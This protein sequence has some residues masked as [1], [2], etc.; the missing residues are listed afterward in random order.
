MD[1]VDVYASLGFGRRNE[2]REENDGRVLQ[3]GVGPNLCCDVP[4][5]CLWHHYIEEDQIRQKIPGGLMSPRRVVLFEDQIAP[6][7]FEK[8]F[9][10]MRSVLVVI[11]N[12]NPPR[13]I[14]N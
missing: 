7:L 13:G 9:D 14:A 6:C 11:N 1:A 2:C 3:F 5:V 10:K 8:N 4:S 12:Q